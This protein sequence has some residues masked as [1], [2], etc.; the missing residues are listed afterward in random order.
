L[1]IPSLGLRRF[2]SALPV[3]YGAYAA[4]YSF[5]PKASEAG[6]VPPASDD[7]FT[8]DLADRL[9]R[10][11]LAYDFAVQL[12]RDEATT[13]IEDGSVE[14]TEATAPWVT[15]GRLTIAQQDV[16]SPRGKKLEEYVEELSFDP[17]HALVEHRPL[18]D[19]M[20]A[21]NAAYRVSTQARKAAAEPDGTERF[22]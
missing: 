4:K 15:V 14:W 2:Y 21:R 18:G 7:H 13:P 19:M 6:G 22:E 16:R 12:F 8:S 3:R 11:P 20:R 9:A 1:K 5:V 17:W 10:A